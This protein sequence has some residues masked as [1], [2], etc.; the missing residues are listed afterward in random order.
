VRQNGEPM[1]DNYLNG[2][3]TLKQI[4]LN[5]WLKIAFM[6]VFIVTFAACEKTVPTKSDSDI[7]ERYESRR[8][9]LEI[10][11]ISGTFQKRLVVKSS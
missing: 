6:T 1:C 5:G 9:N 2:R 7:D 4:N 11:Q 8:G 3:K 10:Y